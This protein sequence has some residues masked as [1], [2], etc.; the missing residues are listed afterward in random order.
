[1]LF[2]WLAG[3]TSGDT[4]PGCAPTVGSRANAGHMSVSAR[5]DRNVFR[6]EELVRNEPLDRPVLGASYVQAGRQIRK[7]LVPL[8]LIQTGQRVDHIHRVVL[9]DEDASRIA[10]P[11][12]LIEESSVLVEHL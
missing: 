2:W 6:S 7:S 5:I 9:G 8:A 12:P 11:S 3:D 4:P 10:E 1:M